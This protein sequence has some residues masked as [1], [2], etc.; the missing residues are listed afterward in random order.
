M[1]DPTKTPP[2]PTDHTDPHECLLALL[3]ALPAEE[4][5]KDEKR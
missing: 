3:A 2:T 4:S 1:T 5:W